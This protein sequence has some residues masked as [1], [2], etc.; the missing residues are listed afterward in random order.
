MEAIYLR[1]LYSSEKEATFDFLCMD[2]NDLGFDVLLAI[3][4]D[5]ADSILIGQVKIPL[6][7]VGTATAFLVPAKRMDFTVHRRL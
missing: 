7:L 4:V 3:V 6:V 5:K 1:I 2:I